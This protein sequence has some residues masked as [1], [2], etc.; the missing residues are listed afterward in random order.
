MKTHP[1]V[2]MGRDFD[3]TQGTIRSALGIA[4]DHWKGLVKELETKA[5]LYD[6]ATP[7]ELAAYHKNPDPDP[8]KP[9]VI[10][11]NI[12]PNSKGMRG[13]A[14]LFREQAEKV[15]ALLKIDDDDEAERCLGCGREEPHY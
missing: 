14:A 15:E 13:M 2:K 5:D 12:A 7:E 10:F 6:K 9:G 11:M 8:E 1:M 3:T 4:L